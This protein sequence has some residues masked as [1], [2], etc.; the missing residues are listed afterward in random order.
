MITQVASVGIFLAQL[1][2][3]KPDLLSEFASWPGLSLTSL[4]QV[5]LANQ[6]GTAVL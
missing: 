4:I 1:W 6:A 2:G 5:W 3:A